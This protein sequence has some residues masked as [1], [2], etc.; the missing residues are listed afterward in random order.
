MILHTLESRGHGKR[1]APRFTCSATG[2]WCLFCKQM[3]G[4]AWDQ[5]SQMSIPWTK[6]T[7]SRP[8]ITPMRWE[9]VLTRGRADL[10]KGQQD[11]WEGASQAS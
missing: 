7:P 1:R 11:V 2:L 9:G 5:P 3:A 10:A 4:L 6:G 8:S